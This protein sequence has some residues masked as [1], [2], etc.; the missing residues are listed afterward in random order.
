[1]LSKINISLSLL[2][3]IVSPVYDKLKPETALISPAEI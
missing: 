2:S 3:I 1:M